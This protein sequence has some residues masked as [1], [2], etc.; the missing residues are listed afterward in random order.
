MEMGKGTTGSTAGTGG[1]ATKLTAANLAT[2][3]GGYDHR[4][5]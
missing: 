4:E 1:M 5:W 3:G 2:S